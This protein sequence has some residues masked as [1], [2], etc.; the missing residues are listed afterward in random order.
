MNV[1]FVSSNCYFPQLLGGTETSTH[2]TCLQLAGVGVK[3]AVLCALKPRGLRTAVLRL[4]RHLSRDEYFADH[5]VGY[6]VYRV[7]QPH[8]ALAALARKIAADA[9]VIT[10]NN[11]PLVDAAL[12]TGL[13]CFLYVHSADYLDL[14]GRG[15]THIAN[16]RFTAAQLEQKFG[17]D[18][19]VIP[20]WINRAR[21][22]TDTRRE[23]V[24][25]VNPDPAKGV[26]TAFALAELRPDIPFVFL[27]SWPLSPARRAA[28]QARAR[29]CGNIT[30]KTA[31]L[32]MRRVYRHARILLA[33][34]ECEESWGRVVTEAQASGIPVI[35][36]NRGG[37]PEAVGP[38]G[39][40]VAG[41]EIAPWQQ[42]LSQLWDNPA[43]YLKYSQHARAHSLRDDIAP[44]RMVEAFVGVLRQRLVEA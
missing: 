31:V 43:D 37:L 14:R 25:F 38:G 26:K 28:Y 16:S 3:P 22:V 24:L 2:E 9:I 34:S 12:A 4:G 23:S 27:E 18:S 39:I 1:L 29:A 7:W 40:V 42:A 19:V 35:A 44:A 13:P 36:S 15:V 8:E 17:I 11:M 21:Y 5:S 6:A 20:P 32:D 41:T 30:W 33:P 10:K